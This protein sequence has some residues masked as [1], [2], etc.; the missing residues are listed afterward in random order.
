M[1][2]SRRLLILGLMA[3]SGCCP[4]QE[5]QSFHDDIAWANERIDA[6]RVVK[7]RLL[8]ADPIERAIEQRLVA[9]ERVSSARVAINIPTWPQHH[10]FSDDAPFFFTCVM[11]PVA[12][13]PPHDAE[14]IFMDASGAVDVTADVYSA[15]ED[16]GTWAIE[17][18]LQRR[19]LENPDLSVLQR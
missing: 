4:Q 6:Q 18:T 3:F 8:A 15:I 2:R 13:S 11:T 1:M 5:T 9:D 17:G 12:V 14:Q 19:E 7:R 16:A 10:G